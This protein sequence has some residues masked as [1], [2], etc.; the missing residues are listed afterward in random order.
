MSTFLDCNESEFETKSIYFELLRDIGRTVDLRVII[1]I[2]AGA[3]YCKAAAP[4]S[5]IWE[6]GPSLRIAANVQDG[7][8]VSGPREM[9]QTCETRT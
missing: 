3:A 5:A 7:G 8:G 9:S 6:S 1:D 4:S 2:I